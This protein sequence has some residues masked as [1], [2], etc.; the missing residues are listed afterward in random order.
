[1]LVGPDITATRTATTTTV[2]V[3]GHAE[4]V[5]GLFSLPVKAVATGPTEDYAAAGSGAM[6]LSRAV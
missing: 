5:F 4:S 2:V 1:M 6:T 3:T